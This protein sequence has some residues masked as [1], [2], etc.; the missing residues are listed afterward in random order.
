MCGQCRTTRSSSHSIPG[1]PESPSALAPQE[2][3]DGQARRLWI[4]RE[5]QIRRQIRTMEE[6]AA[7]DQSAIGF[8]LEPRNPFV[9]QR[10]AGDVGWIGQPM[11]RNLTM[12]RRIVACV[13]IGGDRLIAGA[14]VPV[15]GGATLLLPI[16]I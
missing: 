5:V 16:Q 11:L 4:G 12:K 15:E 13:A 14:P 7:V 3:V 9:K 1:R 10:I 2:G 6:M 8:R